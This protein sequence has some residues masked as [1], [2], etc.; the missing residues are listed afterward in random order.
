MHKKKY[1]RSL[2]ELGRFVVPKQIRKD[3]LLGER[4]M[5][6]VHC[7][8][9]KII[10]EKYDNLEPCF[11]TG[12]STKANHTFAFGHGNLTLSPEGIESLLG[13]LEKFKKSQT[14]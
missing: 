7:D 13:Q 3:L 4:Q 9:E 2:D 12:E 11:I 1:I 8:G 10:V 14:D 5:L 6:E